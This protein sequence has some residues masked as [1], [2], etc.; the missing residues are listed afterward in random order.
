MADSKAKIFVQLGDRTGSRGGEEAKGL[1][2]ACL[3]RAA[4]LTLFA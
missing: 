3:K 2:T 4:S 1:S